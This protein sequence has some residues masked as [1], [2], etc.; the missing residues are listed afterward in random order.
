MI[1]LTELNEDDRT[2][3]NL[4]RTSLINAPIHTVGLSEELIDMI[5]AVQEK[6][7]SEIDQGYDEP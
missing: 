5:N 7:E 2:D 3:L 1:R 6:L 4:L